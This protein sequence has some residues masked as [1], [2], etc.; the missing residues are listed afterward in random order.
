MD[1]LKLIKKQNR[2]VALEHTLEKNLI[3]INQLIENI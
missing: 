1:D 3:K 2:K